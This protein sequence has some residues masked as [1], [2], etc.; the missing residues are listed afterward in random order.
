MK[1]FTISE[2]T[3]TATMEP[4]VAPPVT[5]NRP[6]Q[7]PKELSRLSRK[8]YFSQIFVP[9]TKQGIGIRTATSSR[10]RNGSGAKPRM[11]TQQVPILSLRGCELRVL[12]LYYCPKS[13][14]NHDFESMPQEWRVY[15]PEGLVK[16][17]IK[18]NDPSWLID[19]LY[20]Y[21]RPAA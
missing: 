16:I 11:R 19:Q 6:K 10:S 7:A 12:E 20:T 14:K 4:P 18:S 21:Y 3:D 8:E 1:D 2:T 13:A 17:V 15:G 5:P 9:L